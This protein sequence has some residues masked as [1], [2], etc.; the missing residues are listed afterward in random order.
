MKNKKILSIVLAL[1][2]LFMIPFS[3]NAAEIHTTETEFASGYDLNQSLERARDG[4]IDSNVSEAL[5]NQITV[6]GD[7]SVSYTVEYLGTVSKA[8]RGAG[9]SNMYALTATQKIEAN[10]NTEDNVYAWLTLIWIDHWGTQNEIVEVSGGWNANGRTLSNR[11]VMY[12]YSNTFDS[13]YKFERPYTDRF[14]YTNI[15]MCGLTLTAQSSVNSGGYT[16]NPIEVW[17][18]PTIFD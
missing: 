9:E 7:D 10:N 6:S 1:C 15:G 11:S 17:I 18:T 8:T 4:Y 5:L 13:Y 14:T 3:A 2:M 16:E 12:G